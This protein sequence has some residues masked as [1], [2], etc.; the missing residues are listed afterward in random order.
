MS[1]RDAI[2]SLLGPIHTWDDPALDRCAEL[3]AA[4]NAGHLIVTDGQLVAATVDLPKRETVA[5]AKQIAAAIGRPKP[6]KFADVLA[7]VVVYAA[8]LAA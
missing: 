8:V 6:A 3:V 7:D 4:I 2:V 5:T 1:A